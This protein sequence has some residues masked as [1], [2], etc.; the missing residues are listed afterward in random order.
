MLESERR[1]HDGLKARA[2][3]RRRLRLGDRIDVVAGLRSLGLVLRP[4]RIVRLAQIRVA[5]QLFAL[6]ASTVRP[7]DFVEL[8]FVLTLGTALFAVVHAANLRTSALARGARPSARM[9]AERA[10]GSARCDR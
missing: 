10:G 1:P 7:A 8:R 4:A 3:V 9:R 2:F 6:A 5:H